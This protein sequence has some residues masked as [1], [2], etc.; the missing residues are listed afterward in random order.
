LKCLSTAIVSSSCAATNQTCICLDAELQENVTLCVATSCTVKESLVVKNTSSTLCQVPIR[1][2]GDMYS[3]VSTTLGVISGATVL[4]RVA[5]KFIVHSPWGLDDYFILITL[6]SGIPSSV[7]VPHGLVSNGLG[8]DIWVSTPKQITNFVHA[9][10]ATEI[11]Y[12]AQVSLLK[13]SLLFFYMRIFPAAKVKRLLWGTVVF[14]VLFGITFIVVGVFQ[15]QPISYYWKNWD[16][17]H[18]GTC[19]NINSLGWSNAAISILLDAWMLGI[20]MSQIAGLKLHWKKKIGVAMMFV[21]GTFVTVISIIRLQALVHFAKSQNPTWDN[22]NTA[23]WSS[24]EINVGIICVCMPSLRV[25]LVRLFP[26]MLGSTQHASNKNYLNN[27]HSHMG[28]NIS[29]NKSHGKSKSNGGLNGSGIMKSETYTV[30]YGT[31]GD[32]DSDEVELRNLRFADA[33][34]MK[35][36]SHVSETSV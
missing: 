12:F 33:G 10:Y 21:V 2:K 19:L 4:L 1:N 13:L 24:V 23:L 17:E 3:A 32:R 16:G 20:P 29:V 5:S 18:Q 11:L 26:K 36:S 8:K 15:C 9:F 30:Q 25:L 22:L 6:G 34:G 7:I 14:D 35:S 27:S 31:K 28:G